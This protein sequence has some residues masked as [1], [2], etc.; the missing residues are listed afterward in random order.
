M[1]LEFLEHGYFEFGGIRTPCINIHNINSTSYEIL[2]LINNDNN[3]K[4]GN[5]IGYHINTRKTHTPHHIAPHRTALRRAALLFL[6]LSFPPPPLSPWSESPHCQWWSSLSMSWRRSACAECT[7]PT[8]CECESDTCFH[9]FF[10]F[11]FFIFIFS[12][13]HFCHF[14]FCPLHFSCFFIFHFFHHQFH[15]HVFRAFFHFHFNFYLFIFILFSFFVLP[16]H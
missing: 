12:H 8:H 15:V 5:K 1:S 9:L 10:H 4:I 3:N 6:L 2:C 7:R 11:H 16:V 14:H 13:F